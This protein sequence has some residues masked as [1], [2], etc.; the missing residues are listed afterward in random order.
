MI[1]KI[2]MFDGEIE[3]QAYFTYRC[4]DRLQELGFE[5]MTF[6]LDHIGKSMSELFRFMEKDKTAIVSFNFHGHTPG[7]IF[8]DEKTGEW[9]WDV[10][11][12]PCL[13]IVV[14]HPYY[15]HRFLEQVPKDYLHFSID[16][17]H[18]AY[19]ATYFPQIR[20]GPF[21]PLAGTQVDP[22]E[23]VHAADLAEGYREIPAGMDERTYLKSLLTPEGN[24]KIQAR[25]IDIV[26]TG[27]YSNP[28]KF[29]RYIY[30]NDGE[31]AEF[32]LKVIED[33]L[34]DSTQTVEEVMIRHLEE[35]APGTET[36][37]ILKVLGAS[38]FIDLYVRSVLR[39]RAV[40][41]LVDAGLKVAV[42][43]GGWDELE[44]KH[45]ENLIDGK[46][47]DSLKCLQM[48]QLAKCSLN[49]MPWFKDGAHDRVF[50]TMLNGALLITDSSIYLKE[51]L[52]ENEDCVFYDLQTIDQMPDKVR[53]FLAHPEKITQATAQAY[54]IAAKDHTWAKRADVLA[55][56]L[57]DYRA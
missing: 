50:N 15:Y 56:V 2:V 34:S 21:L 9:L 46:G 17:K 31:F 41:E 52:H 6:H 57:R 14:D 16:R 5:V 43:G 55:Q 12:A 23:F 8:Q 29:D 37:E 1:T 40:Q 4:R 20:R 10:Y 53:D 38:I 42:F 47:V 36:S 19:M 7:D 28:H 27:N 24:L 35:E 54:H 3:T 48:I 25:P 30:R 32:Y 49:V 22:L 13:N 51:L 39:G 44:C 33:L 45:P 11:H 18:D 26:F